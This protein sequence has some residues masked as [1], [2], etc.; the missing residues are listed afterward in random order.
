M[1]TNSVD[2]HKCNTCN[3]IYS[4]YQS[5]WKH[6]KI[7]HKI[8]Y[9]KIN[10]IE[11]PQNNIELHKKKCLSC[12]KIFCRLD[13]LNRHKKHVKLLKKTARKRAHTQ[14]LLIVVKVRVQI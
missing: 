12:N 14:I 2:D 3:K 6:N 8:K 11:L 7:Y 4:S 1:N 5:L 9:T 13:S 10:N